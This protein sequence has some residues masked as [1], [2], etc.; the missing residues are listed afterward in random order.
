MSNMVIK[1]CSFFLTMVGYLLVHVGPCSAQEISIFTPRN[2]EIK[3]FVFSEMSQVDIEKKEKKFKTII[4]ENGWEA[5]IV[6]RSSRQYNSHGY[7]WHMFPNKKEADKV[8]IDDQNVPTYWLDDSYQ[9]IEATE[10]ATGA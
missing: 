3:A 8:H 5:I 9:Q 1:I 10:A 2:T 6:G 7:A 4:A